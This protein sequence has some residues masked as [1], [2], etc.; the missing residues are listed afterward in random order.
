MGVQSLYIEKTEETPEV[1][2]SLEAG[3][4]MLSGR[5]LPEDAFSF[6]KPLI[7]WVE[8]NAEHLNGQLLVEIN[9][10]YF[11][12]S[13]GRYLMELLTKL[14]T[15]VKGSAESK[16]IWVAEEGDEI[17]LDKGVEFASIITL[18]FEFRKA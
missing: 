14:E 16:I 3:R 6:Y 2:F 15:G 1:D 5:S 17:M 12:S 8:H 11:N 13:S 7:H 18:P 4:L 9:L 10:D